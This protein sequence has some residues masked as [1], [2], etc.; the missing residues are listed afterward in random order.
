MA[1][2]QAAPIGVFR[3]DRF[4]TPDAA[5]AE[6]LDRMQ[7]THAILRG[8]RGFLHDLTLEQPLENGRSRIMTMVQWESEPLLDAAARDMAEAFRLERFD[9]QAFLSRLGVTAEFGRYRP[10]APR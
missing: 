7:K 10:I 8:K 1:Q 3:V 6:V 4:D 2:V 5:R 9:R